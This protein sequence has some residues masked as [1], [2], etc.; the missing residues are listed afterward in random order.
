M[1]L[2]PLRTRR[3]RRAQELRELEAFHTVRQ[4]A[5]EELRDLARYADDA[6]YTLD[7]ARTRLERATTAEQVVAVEPYVQ[8][9]RVALGVAEPERRRGYQSV[10]DTARLAPPEQAPAQRVFIAEPRSRGAWLSTAGRRTTT[11]G[12]RA[13]R[14]DE[15]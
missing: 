3:E 13:S 1:T 7:D 2:H 9:A 4:L 6:P 10:L 5:R 12:P 14:R 8:A 11:A 15:R